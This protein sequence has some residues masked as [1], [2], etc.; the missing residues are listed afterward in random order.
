[1]GLPNAEQDTV[2]PVPNPVSMLVE[3]AVLYQK[4]VDVE[5]DAAHRLAEA[6][7][8][9]FEAEALADQAAENLQLAAELL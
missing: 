5:K 2:T 6:Q 4:A 7:R 1:M 9:Y 3:A 8:A